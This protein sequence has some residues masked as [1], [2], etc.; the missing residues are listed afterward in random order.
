M[1][2]DIVILTKSAKHSNYCVAGIDIK[3]RRWIRLV[4]D[5]VATDGA[6]SNFDIRLSTGE[7]CKPL[8]LVRVEIDKPV[9]EGCQTENHLIEKGKK[10]V[11]LDELTIADVVKLHYPSNKPYI[12]GNDRP[13]I[14]G[15]DYMKYSLILAEVDNIKVYNNEFG[16]RK[17]NFT[18]KSHFYQEI[19]VTDPE[20]YD[21]LTYDFKKAY[22]VVSIPKT[23]F[24][25]KYYKFI[26]KIFPI[27]NFSN[28]HAYTNYCD[29]PF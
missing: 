28:N 25:G 20:Y 23:D 16:R 11:K 19:S 5:D 14:N 8:D 2:K 24:D 18:Y 9:P 10:W 22:I 3:T 15:I 6:L 26:A 12:F 7:L 17:A 4:S 1:F 27:D 13:Y 21:G 29:L